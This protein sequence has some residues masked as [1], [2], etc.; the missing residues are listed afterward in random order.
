M[1]RLTKLNHFLAIKIIDS[2]NSLVKLY[3]EDI[4]RLYGITLSIEFYRDP[5][6]P[7]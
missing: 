7:S 6:F 3:I 5:K 2:M 1:D 4:V